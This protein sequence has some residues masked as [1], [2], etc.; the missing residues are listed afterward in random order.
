[1]NRGGIRRDI[2]SNQQEEVAA[3]FVAHRSTVKTPH[4]TKPASSRRTIQQTRIDHV[5]CR[6]GYIKIEAFPSILYC[7]IST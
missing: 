5:P 6:F 4:S 1:M 3:F 7:E 2:H